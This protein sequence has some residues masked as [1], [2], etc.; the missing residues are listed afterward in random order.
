MR[1]PWGKKK[2]FAGKANFVRTQERGTRQRVECWRDEGRF[3]P[4]F[5]SSFSLKNSP[6]LPICLNLHITHWFSL[7]LRMQLLPKL[8]PKLLPNMP[9]HSCQLTA[10][11]KPFISLQHLHHDLTRP[12]SVPSASSADLYLYIYKRNGNNIDGR[13]TTFQD[14]KNLWV[15]CYVIS[16]E[17]KHPENT[18]LFC[19]LIRNLMTTL[20]NSNLTNSKT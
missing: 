13:R 14:D 17:I 10:R 7:Q 2:F 8:L 15:N 12:A 16:K 18:W 9:P 4:S 3:S 11:I 20:K 6:Y 5:P 1:F 19:S